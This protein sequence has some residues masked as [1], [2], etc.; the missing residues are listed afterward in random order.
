MSYRSKVFTRRLSKAI[1]LLEG[2]QRS[3]IR[4]RILGRLEGMK[5]TVA[6]KVDVAEHLRDKFIIKNA[7][8]I[9]GI[10]VIPLDHI[11]VAAQ[12]LRHAK[13]GRVI[14]LNGTVSRYKRLDG[15]TGFTLENPRDVTG[16]TPLGNYTKM[17][18]T[19]I[20]SLDDE[21]LEKVTPEWIENSERMY[22]SG[23]KS[24]ELWLARNKSRMLAMVNKNL[25]EP[26]NEWLIQIDDMLH[27]I[28]DAVLR[29]HDKDSAYYQIYHPLV[30]QILVAP[31]G[32]EIAFYKGSTVP[33]TFLE[34]YIMM[35]QIDL[36]LVSKEYP[37]ECIR[38]EYRQD[39]TAP[40][41][42]GFVAR[43]IDG[44]EI[45]S[46]SL[47]KCSVALQ[48]IGGLKEGY[49]GVAG[50]EHELFV[51]YVIMSNDYSLHPY[52]YTEV[53]KISPKVDNTKHTYKGELSKKQQLALQKKKAINAKKAP[54]V[55]I[56][57]NIKARKRK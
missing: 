5:I 9:A 2:N 25:D 41:F 57:K 1:A 48:A 42:S 38:Q 44:Q 24:S 13:L 50:I 29:G 49:I 3:E 47:K 22:D 17:A 21:D 37:Q 6:G 19:N 10:N 36:G 23:M 54:T 32:F 45:E 4:D 18:A 39:Y 16:S 52:M 43:S 11:H 12:T 53:F 51:K 26:L 31:R 40:Q 56:P 20:Y 46:G 35:A 28:F 30:D 14:A 27:K 7:A 15:S 33:I 8:I 34:S 55:S